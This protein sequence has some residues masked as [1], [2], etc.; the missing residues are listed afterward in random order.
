MLIGRVL[1]ILWALLEPRRRWIFCGLV[2]L[3]FVA[4]VLEMTGMVALFGYTRGLVPDA[5]GRRHGPVAGLLRRVFEDQP[6]LEYV[7]WGGVVVVGVLLAKNLLSTLVHFLLNRFLMKLNERVSKRLFEGYLLARYEVFTHRGVSGPGRNISR[8]FELFSACFG[9]TAQVMSDGAIL[10]MVAILLVIVDPWLTFGAMA[11]FG[12]VGTGLYWS[13]QDLLRTMGKQEGVSRKMASRYLSEGFNGVLDGRLNN[14]RQLFVSR[15]VSA[16]GSSSLIKRRKVLIGRLPQSLNEVL[17]GLTIVCA[18][19]YMTL[20]GKSVTDALPTL[21]IFAF[22]GLR[23]TGAMSRV[24]RG[25]QTIRNKIGEF[26]YFY[27]AV[28]QVAPQLLYDRRDDQPTDQYLSDEEPLPANVDGRLHHELKVRDVSF[29]YLG[30]TKP[31]IS[32]ISLDIPRG[33]FVSFC[34]PSGGGKSTLVLLLMGMLKPQTG[35]I[36]CDGQ[37]ILSHVRAW[38]A[39][40]GYVGQKMFLAA[41]TVRDNVAFGIRADQI[42]DAKVWA[43]LELAAA[44][45]FVREL[46]SGIYSDLKESGSVLSG[47]QKQ[48]IVIARALYKDPEIIFFDE[49]TA[50]LDNLTEREITD[51][52]ARLSGKKTII[53][54]AHR[55]SSIRRSDTIYMLEKGSVVA[56]GSYDE[57]MEH[58]DAFRALALADARAPELPETP[59]AP[60]TPDPPESLSSVPVADNDAS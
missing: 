14:T 5:T 50:A 53:C 49:A 39:G 59:G 34:G 28:S 22:A 45:N 10:I 57:L 11:I 32:N 42:D 25:L 36:L 20:R 8:I 44:A 43:A 9:A 30:T 35:E 23:L 6:Q 18:V 47:G 27:E 41:G 37:T 48:R 40:I 33:S 3:M 15:Y 4:G 38:H 54:V 1:R 51:A 19:L 2:G 16:L 60:N 13:T 55:L 17:L 29:G 56:A 24:N 58:S 12:F 21:A 7:V 46:P 26:D 31:A 52:I